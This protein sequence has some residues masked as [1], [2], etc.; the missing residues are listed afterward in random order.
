MG[1]IK[2]GDGTDVDVGLGNFLKA[3][4]IEDGCIGVLLNA[5][6]TREADFGDGKIKTVVEFEIEIPTEEENEQYIW[7]V[8]KQTLNN[9]LEG[10]GEDCKKWVGQKVKL[11]L[12]K[13]NVF[14][15]IKDVIIGEPVTEEKKAGA[16][17]VGKTV[18]LQTMNKV[19]FLIDDNLETLEKRINEFC[20]QNN[21]IATQFLQHESVN[22]IVAIW[23]KTG[24][25]KI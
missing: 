25:I 23:Y 24:V 11:G 2:L 16:P 18:K 20:E 19:K 22:F 17:K 14:G 12:V 4:N 21:V 1:N 7:T 5:G 13:M 15:K 8:N 6:T 10:Y 3:E 9:L